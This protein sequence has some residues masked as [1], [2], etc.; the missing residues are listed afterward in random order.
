MTKRHLLL[1]QWS[2][3]LA[4]LGGALGQP[5]FAGVLLDAVRRLVDFDFVMAFAYRGKG[6]PVILGDTL[7]RARHRVIATDYAAGPFLLD[8]FYQLVSDGRRGGCY[9]LHDVAPDHFRRSEYFREH[10]SRTGIGEEVGFVFP[11]EDGYVGVTSLA[12]W[13][14][15]PPLTRADLEILQAT[16]PAVGAFSRQHWRNTAT[17]AAEVK[18]GPSIA[19]IGF[20]VLSVRE[21]EIVTMILQ[22]HSTQSVALQL[23]ISPGTVKIHRKNIYRKLKISTQ[24]ELFAAFLGGFAVQA[25]AY[26][27]GGIP[28]QADITQSPLNLKKT[29]G[30][31]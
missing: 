29:G 28:T 12:R 10:Y 3:G 5:Q 15:S 6:Q 8:P 16:E 1:E 24:G 13:T 4:E 20:R 23:D 14:Q 21:R 26:S 31:P 25:P 22:G 30:T 18:A 7:D 19:H 2:K 11:M 27:H 17:V 9:R